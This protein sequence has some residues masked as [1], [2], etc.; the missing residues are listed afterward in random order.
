[1]DSLYAVMFVAGLASGA[2]V[3]GFGAYGLAHAGGLGDS[4]RRSLLCL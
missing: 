1:M 2:L 3:L 4:I